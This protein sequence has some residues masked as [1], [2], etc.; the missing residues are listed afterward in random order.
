MQFSSVRVHDLC[1]ISDGIHMNKVSKK[2]NRNLILFK[3]I[4]FLSF[5]K[6]NL[7]FLWKSINIAKLSVDIHSAIFF[8]ILQFLLR[9]KKKKKS[10]ESFWFPSWFPVWQGRLDQMTSRGIFQPKAFYNSVSDMS[11]TCVY[12]FSQCCA[13]TFFKMSPICWQNCACF[14]PYKSFLINFYHF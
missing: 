10:N 8:L 11:T 6:K 12:L 7:E 4:S 1:W 14:C 5:N 2:T 9:G 13:S 3:N